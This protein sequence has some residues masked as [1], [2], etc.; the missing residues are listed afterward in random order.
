MGHLSILRKRRSGV[1]R[2]VSR[3]LHKIEVSVHFHVD[4]EYGAIRKRGEILLRRGIVHRYALR[5]GV[6]AVTVNKT[7]AGD[8][9]VLLV[10][11]AHR[12]RV[13]FGY[14][15]HDERV[16][17]GAVIDALDRNDFVPRR[18]K[19]AAHCI[20]TRGIFLRRQFQFHRILGGQD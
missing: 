3:T 16:L 15:Q 9:R 12:Q 13:F 10:L 8:Y 11:L 6:H 18:F 1:H 19:V 20:I 5:D 17:I 7:V 2:F 4:L 14:A